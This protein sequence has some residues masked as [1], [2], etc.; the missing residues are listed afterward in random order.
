MQAA[1]TILTVAKLGARAP[2]FLVFFSSMQCN[3]LLPSLLLVLQYILAARAVQDSC[4]F[5]VGNKTFNTTKWR[6]MTYFGHD[7]TYPGGSYFVSV[8]GDLPK[9]C[10]DSLTGVKVESRSFCPLVDA[11]L[12][13][14]GQCLQ[15]LWAKSEA[16]MLGRH[17]KVLC[18]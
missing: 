17:R 15:A 3:A 16:I 12:T 1:G 18:M 8:C 7:L 11:A 5:D 10:V 6:N 2:G 13:D 9:P 14:T 4:I